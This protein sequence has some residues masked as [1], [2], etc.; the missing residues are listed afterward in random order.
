MLCRVAF[1]ANFPGRL[2]G[3]LLCGGRSSRMG[4]DKALIEVEGE[5]LWLRQRRKLREVLG[6]EP[7]V[8]VRSG[9]GL[10]VSGIGGPGKESGGLEK[11]S[12]GLGKNSDASS[13][14]VSLRYVFDDGSLG[15]LG[16]IL[17][18][19]DAIEAEGSGEPATHLAVLAVDMPYLETAWWA[20]L[21]RVCTPAR[22][23]IGKRATSAGWEPLA[24]IYPVAMRPIFVA[25]KA[26]ANFSLQQIGVNGIAAGLLCE[27]GIGREDE[28]FFRNWNTPGDINQPF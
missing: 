27:V 14:G 24:A 9:M 17:A 26:E 3:V 13:N 21:A 12:S 5:A 8:S 10:A 25:A 19:F 1:V 18:A 7:L 23:A 2:E 28:V 16:G 20:T 11:D 22:G 4:R 15:P 6:K